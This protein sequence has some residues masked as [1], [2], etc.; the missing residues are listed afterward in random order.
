[1]DAKTRDLTLLATS[2]AELCYSYCFG[3]SVWPVLSPSWYF[4]SYLGARI[5]DFRVVRSITAV[6]SWPS[7]AGISGCQAA[8]RNDCDAYF[9]RGDAGSSA[10]VDTK[11]SP[12]IHRLRRECCWDMFWYVGGNGRASHCSWGEG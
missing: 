4:H 8:V 10:A 6:H 11:S 3:R 12:P 2:G 5:Q 9:A 1:M 7:R